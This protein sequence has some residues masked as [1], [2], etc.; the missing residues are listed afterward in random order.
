MRTPTYDNSLEVQLTEMLCKLDENPYVSTS[1]VEASTYKGFTL[2]QGDKG[3]LESIKDNLF[4]NFIAYIESY[5]VDCIN[6]YAV[7]THYIPI[8]RQITE[9]YGAAIDRHY[10]SEIRD[11]WA[12]YFNEPTNPDSE[13]NLNK[14]A[15]QF[16]FKATGVQILFLRKVREILNKHLAELETA[17]P[18]PEPEYFFTVLPELTKRRHDILYDLHK[19]L[20]AKG[21]I[22]CTAEAFKNVFTTKEPKSISWLKS[23][24]SLTYMVRS[25]TGRLLEEKAKPSNAYITERY[26]HIY[27][28]DGTMLKPKKIRHDKDPNLR[29]MMFLDKVIEDAISSF[30]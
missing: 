4:D 3:M 25:M 20:K 1:P 29:V 13:Y 16:F 28:K 5:K 2:E 24:R 17:I 11:G 10:S 22:D 26:I 9:Q 12:A 30:V 7:N 18:K 27:K 8:I 14:H 23:Q 15:Y 6:A 19:N 21:Y